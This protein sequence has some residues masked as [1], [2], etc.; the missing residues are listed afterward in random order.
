MNKKINYDWLLFIFS[1]VCIYILAPDLD[2]RHGLWVSSCF[3][4]I[5]ILNSRIVYELKF[6]WRY[7]IFFGIDLLT[8]FILFDDRPW[9][10]LFGS[11]LFD[12]SPFPLIICSL[13]MSA[14]GG[15]L[16]RT[17]PKRLE[18]FLIT[19]GLQIPIAI[20]VGTP[21][22]VSFFNR[23]ADSLGFYHDYFGAWQAWQFEWMLT[24]Y[25][26]MYFLNKNQASKNK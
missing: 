4:L 2:R 18:Y 17:W 19:S 11:G 21:F 7:F 12:S 26:P 1:L 14:A 13:I 10:Y 6:L 8:Y 25:I 16:L 5:L 20:F 22:F 24:Y 3:A 9:N 23:M 15:I